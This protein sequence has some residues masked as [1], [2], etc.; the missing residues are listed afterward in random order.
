MDQ[1]TVNVIG[2]YLESIARQSQIV[3]YGQLVQR[4][5][6]P[7]LDGAWAAHP[8]AQIFDLIDQQDAKAE[9]PFRTSVVVGQG[10]NMPGAGFFEALERFKGIE[11][12]SNPDDRLAI[13]MSELNSAYA[14]GWA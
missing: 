1:P 8:L 2:Q 13:W 14:Y 9:R 6:L 10:S 11:V 4:F 3:T 5:D 7:P 12:N